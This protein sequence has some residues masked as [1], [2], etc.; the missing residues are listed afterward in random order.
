MSEKKQGVKVLKKGKIKIKKRGNVK[1]KTKIPDCNVLEE[2][3]SEL[4]SNELNLYDAEQAAY[5]K[6]ISDKIRHLKILILT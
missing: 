2:K 6:C 4:T 5:L 1:I 3:Y